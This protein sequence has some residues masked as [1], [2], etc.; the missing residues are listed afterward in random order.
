MIINDSKIKI[1]CDTR[2]R[3][4]QIYQELKALTN[5]SFSRGCCRTVISWRLPAKRSGL[6]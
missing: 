2:E 6:D 1:I 4:S 3:V 5:D